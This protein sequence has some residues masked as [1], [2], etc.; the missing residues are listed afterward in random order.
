MIY[1]VFDDI[2]FDGDNFLS[3]DENDEEEEDE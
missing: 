3:G 1:H 2:V